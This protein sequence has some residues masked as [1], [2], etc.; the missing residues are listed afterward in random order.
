MFLCSNQGWSELVVSG[1]IRRGRMLQ[2]IVE[3][4]TLVLTSRSMDCGDEGGTSV[5][6]SKTF[7]CDDAAG[8]GGLRRTGCPERR[9]RVPP[10]L[11][12]P[13][14]AGWKDL[15]SVGGQVPLVSRCDPSSR[16]TNP[17][18]PDAAVSVV[19]VLSGVEGRSGQQLRAPVFRRRRLRRRAVRVEREGEGEGVLMESMKA[20]SCLGDADRCAESELEL[21]DH[22]VSR[23]ATPQ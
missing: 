11:F 21:V 17:P 5:S 23:L 9:G 6:C 22:W 12:L 16:T 20:Q 14:R 4:P 3:Q 18:H 19:R 13:A 1:G 7:V 8:C 2:N 10:G 15:L